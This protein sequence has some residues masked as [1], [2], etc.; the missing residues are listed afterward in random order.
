MFDFTSNQV[1]KFQAYAAKLS[2]G[3]DS[4][5]EKTPQRYNSW[6]KA[7]RAL[8]PT[9]DELDMPAYSPQRLVTSA[10]NALY[11]PANTLYQRAGPRGRVGSWKPPRREQPARITEA[12]KLSNMMALATFCTSQSADH[13][14]PVGSIF[15]SP[16]LSASNNFSD[17]FKD[18]DNLQPLDT[19][20]VLNDNPTASAPANSAI[21][22]PSAAPNASL[23]GPTVE[24]LHYFTCA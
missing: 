23:A 20:N 1:A 11:Q 19:L 5:T 15:G 21:T 14:T 8:H 18:L 4:I 13:G 7:Y 2:A 10:A 22:A 9:I 6:V 3:D 16:V 12:D 24:C 17:L